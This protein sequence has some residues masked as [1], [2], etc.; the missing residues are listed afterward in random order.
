MK[1]YT[2]WSNIVGFQPKCGPSHLRHNH[3][4]A[5]TVAEAAHIITNFVDIFQLFI[6]IYLL[7]FDNSLNILTRM[8]WH[9]SCYVINLRKPS[10]LV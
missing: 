3:W 6:Y 5:D 10:C 1:F 4:P 7:T 9:R 8:S 2:V